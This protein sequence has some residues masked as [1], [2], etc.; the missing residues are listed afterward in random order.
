MVAKQD[1]VEAEA[2]AH[3]IYSCCLVW[4]PLQWKVGVEYML[5][6]L[7]HDSRLPHLA[8]PTV[9]GVRFLDLGLHLADS[10]A[11]SQIAVCLDRKLDEMGAWGPKAVV[12]KALVHPQRL[13]AA[14]VARAAA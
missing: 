12:L 5:V 11:S 8:Q 13:Q 14:V 6:I 7:G 10:A 4:S 1:C 2:V 9:V 3:K